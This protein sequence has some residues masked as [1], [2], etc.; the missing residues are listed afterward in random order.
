MITDQNHENL[1]AASG[2]AHQAL[3]DQIAERF[4]R[5]GPHLLH[6]AQS[7]QIAPDAAEDIVQETLLEAWKSLDHL[8][9]ETRF[10]AWLDGICRNICRRH[11]RKQGLLLARERPLEDIGDEADR[12]ADLADPDSFDPTEELLRQDRAYLLDRA[13]GHLSPEERAVVERHYLAEIPQRELANQMGLTLSALEARLHRAR[14]HLL[15]TFGDSLHD[16]A[17]ALGLAV[18]PSDALHWRQTRAWC[19]FCG[20]QRLEGLF[21]PLPDGRMNLRLRCPH[22]KSF[23]IDSLGIIDLSSARSFL[24]AIKKLIDA[25]GRFFLTTM[26]ASG[27]CQCWICGRSTHLSISRD[28]HLG[29]Q[30]GAHTRL[31]SQC[32]CIH[33]FASVPTLYGAL[34]LVREFLL[35]AERVVI[36]PEEE[37]TYVGQSA[38]RF[39]LLDLDWGRRVSIFADIET[40]LP[41][42]VV[43]E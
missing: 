11:Q 31:E 20:R 30:G 9:D 32:A 27:A 36:G 37:T 13:L 43:L 16:E 26:S 5:A 15:H 22:C 1:S 3:T 28:T 34:P 2:D 10:A 17:M 21:E 35:G 18:V 19:I 38:I 12:F 6:L 39:S 40:L 25:A 7:Q 4:R 8:R 14:S 24:P 29:Y 33:L 42:E 23:E 41:L